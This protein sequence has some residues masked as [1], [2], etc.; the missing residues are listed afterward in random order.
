MPDKKLIDHNATPIEDDSGL[1]GG[2]QGGGIAELIE[3]NSKP[4]NATAPN[5]AGPKT[6]AGRSDQP[7][8]YESDATDTVSSAEGD[9]TRHAS[10]A[11]GKTQARDSAD[12]PADMS[13][14]GFNEGDPANE[15][16]REDVS[17]GTRA[18]TSGRPLTRDAADGE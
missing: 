7:L 4:S 18:S 15:P 2:T 5:P 9:G 6:G 10:L 16:D 14:S 13:R 1:R 12:I 11:A 17:S 3:V 8:G